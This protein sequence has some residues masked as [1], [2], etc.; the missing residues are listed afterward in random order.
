[1]GTLS[2]HGLTDTSTPSDH[3]IDPADFG[4]KFDPSGFNGNLAPTDD[5][6]QKVF[7]KV[8]NLAGGG[9]TGTI[10]TPNDG[11]VHLTPKSSSTGAEG[12]VFYC[13][14][15]NSVYVACE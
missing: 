6:L 9:S 2:D 12:T 5:T 11:E 8:D 7:D 15:D 13:S 1:M 14:N 10:A 4:G 3:G